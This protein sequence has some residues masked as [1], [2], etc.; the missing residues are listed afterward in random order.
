MQPKTAV[1][2]LERFSVA[3]IMT[4]GTIAKSYFAAEE[5]LHNFEPRVREIISALRTDDLSFTFCDLM[6]RDS[7]EIGPSERCRIMSE[8]SNMVDLH[9]AVLVTHGTDS[10]VETGEAFCRSMGPPRVPV[11]FTG[12]MIPFAVRGSDA[13]QNVTESLLALRL[14]PPGTYIVFHNRILPLPGARKDYDSLTFAHA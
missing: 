13:V 12:A 2:D 9:D 5:R 3:V 8:I 11:I 1:T 7:S 6:H 10:L 14:L 4:G